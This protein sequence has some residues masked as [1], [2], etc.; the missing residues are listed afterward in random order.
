[1]AAPAQK[2]PQKMERPSLEL[3]PSALIETASDGSFQESEGGFEALVCP[4]RDGHGDVIDAVAWR[5]GAPN[6]WWRYRCL[7]D[8]LGAP[9]LLKAA[10]EPAEL[11]LYETPARWL[12]AVGSKAICILDWSADLRLLFGLVHGPLTCES[13]RLEQKF[14]ATLARQSGPQLSDQIR[15]LA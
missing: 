11:I 15:L 9:A 13:A 6:V 8:V 14:L 10:W 3:R 4:V 1:M 7:G 2:W 5:L 12:A